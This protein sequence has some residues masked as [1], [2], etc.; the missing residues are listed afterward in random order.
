[1]FFEVCL[2]TIYWS[3]STCPGPVTVDRKSEKLMD[4][5]QNPMEPL[6]WGLFDWTGN[7]LH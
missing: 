3:T 4:S 1:M 6:L 5:G 2:G 7:H